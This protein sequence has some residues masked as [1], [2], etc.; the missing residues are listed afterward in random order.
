MVKDKEEIRRIRAA[1]KLGASLFQVAR[2]K[3]RPG[4]KEV[5]VAAAMETPGAKSGR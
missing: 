5:E 1:I 2:K 4:V 3:I